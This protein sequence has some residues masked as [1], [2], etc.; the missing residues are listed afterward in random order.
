[1]LPLTQIPPSTSNGVNTTYLQNVPT[2]TSHNRA[3]DGHPVVGLIL[4][5]F[6][7]VPVI[8][9][10]NDILLETQTSQQTLVQI[11]LDLIR[12]TVQLRLQTL[13]I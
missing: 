13:N 10:G 6:P 2:G 3:G 5:D 4:H 1:M 9:V 8:Q 12:S 11:H 7:A